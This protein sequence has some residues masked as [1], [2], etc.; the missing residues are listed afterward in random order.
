MRAFPALALALVLAAPPAAGRIVDRIAAVVNTDVITLSEVDAAL[1]RRPD[2]MDELRE[3]VDREQI[4][5]K[6][7]RKALDQ[8]IAERLL[9]AEIRK[10]D[11]KA[12]ELQIERAFELQIQANRTTRERFGEELRKAGYTV[13]TYKEELARRLQRQMLLER[14][15]LPKIK[16]ADEDVKNYYTQNV[17]AINAEAVE[18]CVSH[19]LLQTP[20]GAPK[21]AV[22]TQ[23]KL[24]E[25]LAARAKKGEDFADLARKH[26]ADPTATRGGDLGCFRRGVMV[27]EFEKAVFGLRKGEIS[28]VVRT[29]FG[30]HVAKLYDIKGS[31]VRPFAEVKEQ[32]RLKLV[33]DAMERQVQ[34][35]VEEQKKKAF[36]D[37]K[38]P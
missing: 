22:E 28:G 33:Q 36:V 1:Q 29:Q 25:E 2:L 19:I 30:F 27:A 18:Y 38:I 32:I 8:L 15:F 31:G 20:A 11:I 16:V 24:A 17:N 10:L 12:T 14:L 37:V 5:A 23:Q 4:H 6:M 34:R 7:R 21:E 26:S 13:S 3:A 9:E 35:W